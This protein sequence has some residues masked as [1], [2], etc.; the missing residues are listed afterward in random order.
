MLPVRDLMLSAGIPVDDYH[1]HWYE[2]AKV[3]MITDN[4]L[5]VTFVTVG[6]TELHVSGFMTLMDIQSYIYPKNNQLYVPL[7]FI[8]LAFQFVVDWDAST[9]TL[10]I[11]IPE[12]LKPQGG[13]GPG[14]QQ[15]KPLEGYTSLSDF[16]DIPGSKF[17][18]YG[19][20]TRNELSPYFFVYGDKPYKDLDEAKAVIQASGLDKIAEAEKGVIVLVNP[21]E[22]TWGEKDIAV[23]TA[24]GNAVG[25][26]RAELQYL[27][28]EGSGATFINNYLS[29]N[30]G[31]LS[32]ALTFGG[33]IGSPNPSPVNPLPVYLVSASKN[34]VDYY[35]SLNDQTRIIPSS[36]RLS[37]VQALWAS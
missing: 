13:Q 32:G 28:G 36:G 9:K 12:G 31:K 14:G 2:P 3:A 1:F 15:S 10:R 33:E 25:T 6:S 27:I 34:A 16:G 4:T 35:K 19:P 11:T 20:E 7:S 37:N 22:K 30:C 18:F 24:I 17:Y 23:F 5:T 8:P 29:L 21:L 26:G